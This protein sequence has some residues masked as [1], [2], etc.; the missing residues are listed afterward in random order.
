MSARD[1]YEDY[2]SDEGFNPATGVHQTAP[3]LLTP[4][5]RGECLDFGCG[6]G[7]KA[8]WLSS[9]VD[10]YVGADIS[11][12]AVAR[13]QEAGFEAIRVDD[14]LP[15]EDNS[16][17]VAVAFDVLEHLFQPQLAVAEILRVLRPSGTI[18]CSVPNAAYWRRRTDLAAGRWNPTGDD[19]AV[20]APWRDPHIRFFTS[21]ALVRMLGSA[22]VG[23]VVIQGYGGA[24]VRDV[25]GLRRLSSRPSRIYRT[26]EGCLP[27]LLANTLLAS[28]RR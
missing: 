19:M 4:H 20:E 8:A 7:G 15:F 9:Y 18:L 22:G 23:N 1:Y 13:V 16:F 5:L 12:K 26:L 3:R 25:P 21:S 14:G 24:F 28:G 11:A 17:D 2:W 27:S 6:D 10:S